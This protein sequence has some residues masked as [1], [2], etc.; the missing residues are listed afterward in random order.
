MMA[1]YEKLHKL[2]EAQRVRLK[3]HHFIIIHWRSIDASSHR[4]LHANGML[5]W[6]DVC[7]QKLQQ[8]EAYNTRINKKLLLNMHRHFMRKDK[9]ATLRKEI[10]ILAQTHGIITL[11]SIWCASLYNRSHVVSIRATERDVDRKDA[12][13]AMLAKDLD[14]A[15]EQYGTHITSHV[16]VH[17]SCY[18]S[19]Y[20]DC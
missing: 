2:S 9:V 7:E 13:I 4:D 17:V 18:E 5:W 1:E 14:D 3:V 12:I 11:G 8:Q 15:E 16:H 6:Y 19:Y 10:E 20:V